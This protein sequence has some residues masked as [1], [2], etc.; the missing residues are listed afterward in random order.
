EVF[1]NGKRVATNYLKYEMSG[2]G[3][4]GIITYLEM[5]EA[6]RGKNI[7]KV[8]KKLENKLEWELPFYYAPE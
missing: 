4:F 5:S 7:L 1:L 6:K 3:Q 8:I 2:T